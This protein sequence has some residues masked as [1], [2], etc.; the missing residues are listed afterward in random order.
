[1]ILSDAGLIAEIIASVATLM[2]LV[3]LG[4]QIRTS[5]VLTR[6]ESARELAAAQQPVWLSIVENEKVSE[7]FALGLS[8]RKI[9]YLSST[10]C[11]DFP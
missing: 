5:N 2:T 11:L 1:M 8:I 9:C 7:L 6:S 4:L 10:Y 3:Y